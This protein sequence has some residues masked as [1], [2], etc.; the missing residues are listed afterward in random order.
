M[1][2]KDGIKILIGL[3]PVFLMAGWLESYITRL[4]E[5]PLIVKLLIILV[6]LAFILGYYVIYPIYLERKMGQAAIADFWEKTAE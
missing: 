5:M 6:S 2:F 3:I 4:T 1:F